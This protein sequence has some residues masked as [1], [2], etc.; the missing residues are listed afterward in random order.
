MPNKY[1]ILLI[2]LTCF[3]SCEEA[4][5][6]RYKCETYQCIESDTGIFYSLE[7]CLKNC[8]P[9]P[10]E[11]GI[12]VTVFIYENCPIAQYMCG[13]LRNSYRYFCDTLGANISFHGIS[14][15]PLSTDESLNEFVETYDIPFD[16][17]VD[18]N[19]EYQKKYQP[20]VTPEV[21]IEYDD[22][23]VYR[24]MI[25]NS[26]QDW[27]QWAPATEHYLMDVLT[28][29]VNGEEITYFETTAIGCYINPPNSN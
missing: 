14:P 2:L 5:E 12:V 17:S 18:L 13:P 29:I 3:F 27:G 28:N 7:T 26:Y 9:K 19:Y 22:Q 8:S 24:G 16:V 6:K 25:D 4:I 21:F 15:D 10:N 1:Y 20:I 11:A 23:L